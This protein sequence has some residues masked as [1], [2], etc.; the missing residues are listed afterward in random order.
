M[1]HYLYKDEVPEWPLG[2][3]IVV[4]FGNHDNRKFDVRAAIIRVTPELKQKVWNVATAMAID[5]AIMRIDF[6]WSMSVITNEAF[7][8][9]ILKQHNGAIV[10]CLNNNFSVAIASDAACAAFQYMDS[11][12]QQSW[13][14][15]ERSLLGYAAVSVGCTQAIVCKYKYQVDQFRGPQLPDDISASEE[16]SGTSNEVWDDTP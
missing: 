14:S 3:S 4:V 1:S 7:G 8:R 12:I 16:S 5:A 6:E 15:V 9:P 10:E 11:K 13:I 2:H